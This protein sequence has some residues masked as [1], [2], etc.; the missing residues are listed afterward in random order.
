[1]DTFS[2]QAATVVKWAMS[3]LVLSIHPSIFICEKELSFVLYQTTTLTLKCTHLD[4]GEKM[5]LMILV[6]IVSI[7]ISFLIQ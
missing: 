1:M 2:F 6:K 5:S 7:N 4:L 3:K